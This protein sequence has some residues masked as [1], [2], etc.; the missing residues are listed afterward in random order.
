MKKKI[1]IGVAGLMVLLIA[2]LG[3]AWWQID[4]IAREGIQRGT[5][6]ATGL[7]TT[8]SEV[9]LGLLGGT[10]DVQGL[11][12]DNPD[13]FDTPYLLRAGGIDT[14]VTLGSLFGSPVEV[15]HL[16]LH[17]L[18]VHL[19]QKGLKTNVQVVMDRLK[20]PP[21]PPGESPTPGPAPQPE[22]NEPAPPA[23][24]KKIR[25]ACIVVSS[26]TAYVRGGMP[27]GKTQEYTVRVPEIVLT[28]LTAD[29]KR[30]ITVDELVRRVLPAILATVIKESTGKVPSQLLGDFRTDL[31]E[32][33][34]PQARE[35]LR[36]VGAEKLL[37]PN[38]IL[39]KT[40]ET[41]T[42]GLLNRLRQRDSQ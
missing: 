38:R 34:S 4:A 2:A 30:G 5:Q 11:Q 24:G 37:D 7:N 14:G 17:N 29:T 9:S 42:D 33:L 26:V 28:D 39:D 18:E 8:V 27:G 15:R 19:E 22:P 31:L 40:G 25:V 12:I 10:L 35:L 20:K 36:E 16:N 23:E 1:L 32:D 6:R 41:V 3:I 13:G 21:P